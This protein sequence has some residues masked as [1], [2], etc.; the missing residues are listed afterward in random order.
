MLGRLLDSLDE[1][2]DSPRRS[3]TPR[4][5]SRAMASIQSCVQQAHSEV[6]AS[7]QQAAM[8]L[9]RLVESTSVPP[10]AVGP[11]AHAIAKLCA[12]ENRT[13]ACYAARAAKNL[14]LADDLRHQATAAGL[15]SALANATDRWLD[16]EETPCLR[17]LLGALQ[18][19]AGLSGGY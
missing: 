8:Q 3:N 5:R 12:S 16:E 7:Q 17:E 11:L 18:T 4:T 6:P 9:S 2:P 14:L 15:T 1:L 13:V 19:L 10:A